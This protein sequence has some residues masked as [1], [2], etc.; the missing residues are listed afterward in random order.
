MYWSFPIASSWLSL[1][2]SYPL[3]SHPSLSLSPLCLALLKLCCFV[4]CPVFYLPLAL[5]VLN[6][7]LRS[8][9]FTVQ[10]Q[11][12]WSA[13][14]ALVWY[15]YFMSCF[16]S[17]RPSI[18]IDEFKLWLSP[19]E[20]VGMQ[21][22]IY[23]LGICYPLFLL[24]GQVVKPFYYEYSTVLWYC[25]ANTVCLFELVLNLAVSCTPPVKASLLVFWFSPPP[26]VSLF[27]SL[28]LLLLLP[29][30][31]LRCWYA[32][33]RSLTRSCIPSALSDHLSTTCT[34]AMIAPRVEKTKGER[35]YRF[36]VPISPISL[37]SS[38]PGCSCSCC[39]DTRKHP[40]MLICKASITGDLSQTA[41]RLVNTK[42]PTA[43]TLKL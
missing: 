30:L 42:N 1:F 16:A 36:I 22:P 12:A 14:S 8:S 31:H 23:A 37:T 24:L 21:S 10:E 35:P 17:Y 25:I 29:H 6:L 33:L 2:L 4:L 39:L 26:S 38:R 28:L 11:K 13:L 20:H 3:L 18:L 40:R 5:S 34:T 15:S 9:L 27:L 19:N 7:L 43:G 41:F 32:L